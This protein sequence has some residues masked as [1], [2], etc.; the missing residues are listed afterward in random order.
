MHIYK[1]TFQQVQ[2]QV[3]AAA[4]DGEVWTLSRK[5]MAVSL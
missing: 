3:A 4:G 1:G 2:Q 5:H